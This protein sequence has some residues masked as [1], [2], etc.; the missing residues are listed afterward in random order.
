VRALVG[1]CP[2]IEPAAFDFPRE[3]ANE[4]AGMLSGVSGSDL[5]AQWSVL[6]SLS[7]YFRELASRPLLLVTGDRDELAPPSHFSEI[8][9]ALDDVDW[10]RN[11]EGDHSFSTCRPWLV[12]TV[13]DWL[14]ARL[15]T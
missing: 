13:T 9:A 15:G 12:E 11:P 14:V 4:F 6:E 3:M 8:V 1:L 10:I 2:F 7:G 5:L